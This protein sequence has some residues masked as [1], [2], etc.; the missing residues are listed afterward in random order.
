ML[1][2]QIIIAVILLAV[3]GYA[4]S[5][6]FADDPLLLQSPLMQENSKAELLL[7]VFLPSVLHVLAS[8]AAAALL[9]YHYRSQTG[10]EAQILPAVFLASTVGYVM[11]L[12]WFSFVSKY[13]VLSAPTISAVY[14]FSLLF[15]A[16]GYAG[17]A[18]MHNSALEIN[19]NRYLLFIFIF[20]VFAVS[21][22]PITSNS[23]QEPVVSRMPNNMFSSIVLAIETIAVGAFIID[24]IKE[25]N[26]HERMRNLAFILMTAGTTFLSTY[27]SIGFNAVGIIL[28]VAGVSLLVFLTRAYQV[29]T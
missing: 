11:I 21:I 14:H 8:V 23:L 1:V 18:L 13:V 16:L 24:L 25:S 9:R 3:M 26:K 2:V 4:I 15:V 22:A 6:L 12:P 27:F 5:R 17:C 7:N 28:F 19:Q 10:I 20:S 29:W